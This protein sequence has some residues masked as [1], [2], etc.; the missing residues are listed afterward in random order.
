M[1]STFKN[2]IEE[3]ISEPQITNSQIKITKNPNI[4]T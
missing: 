1:I 2:Q 4:Q 3:K